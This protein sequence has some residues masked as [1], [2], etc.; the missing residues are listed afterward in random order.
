MCSSLPAFKILDWLNQPQNR[1][2]VCRQSANETQLVRQVVVLP[3]P[4]T[5][6]LVPYV[7]MS[8]SYQKRWLLLTCT[9][10]LPGMYGNGRYPVPVNIF[11]YGTGTGMPNEIM[12]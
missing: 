4:G 11:I 3:V 6:Y 5:W 12:I 7:V 1:V 9:I 10:I 2:P 8:N